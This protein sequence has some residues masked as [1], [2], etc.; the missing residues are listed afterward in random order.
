MFRAS[1]WKQGQ[2]HYGVLRLWAASGWTQ[3]SSHLVA[4]KVIVATGGTRK[5]G[6]PCS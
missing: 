2:K 4:E 6:M 1:R 5:W 3:R